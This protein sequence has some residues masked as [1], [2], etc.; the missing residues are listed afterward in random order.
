MPRSRCSSSNR[1]TPRNASRRISIVHRSP[2]SSSVPAIEQSTPSIGGT[3][4]RQLRFATHSEV[5]PGDQDV[6]VRR[7]Y[8]IT[9]ALS[10]GYGSIYTLLADMRDRYGF[11]EA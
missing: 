5:G 1:R 4:H 7:Y 6:P 9:G 11:S 8:L 3:L 10:L 2:I